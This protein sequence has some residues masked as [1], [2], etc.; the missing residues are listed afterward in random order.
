MPTGGTKR[1]RPDSAAALPARQM[2][3]VV[4][5]SSLAA[6]DFETRFSS[7]PAILCGLVR[8]WNAASF[9]LSSLA[10]AADPELEVTA[11]AWRAGI[12]PVQTHTHPSTAIE[13]PHNSD[14]GG[15]VVG[16]G[17]FSNA[18]CGLVPD[19]FVLPL[20]AERGL[21]WPYKGVGPKMGLAKLKCNFRDL[22]QRMLLGETVKKRHQN[23]TTPPLAP[24]HRR[25]PR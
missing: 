5:A 17:A 2:A 1:K 15:R 4:D 18:G 12:L 19:T 25:P 20:P 23:P 6:H 16:G 7:R 3:R 10:A 14:G 22:A 24:G 11:M 8:T 13:R 9:C 21:H